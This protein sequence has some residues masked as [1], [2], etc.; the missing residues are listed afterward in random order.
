MSLPWTILAA[1]SLAA[2]TGAQGYRLGS[3]SNEARHVAQLAQERLQTLEAGDRA[4]DAE[5]ARLSA[6][7]K[8]RLIA[9]ALEDQAYAAPVSDAVC[10]PV[11]RVRR[12]NLR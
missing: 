9:Q 7:T 3:A 4:A 11:E 12:L 10:L 2:L 1:L 8:V 5:R 6:E